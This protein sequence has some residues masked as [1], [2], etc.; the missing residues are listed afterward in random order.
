MS[1]KV[2]LDSGILQYVPKG[3]YYEGADQQFATVKDIWDRLLSYDRVLFALLSLLNGSHFSKGMISHLLL[4]NPNNGKGLVTKDGPDNPLVPVGLDDDFEKN[5][6]LFNLDKIS[7]DSMPRALKNLLILTG[8]DSNAKRVNN[9]RTRKIILEFIFNRDNRQLDALAVNY[10]G[11]LAK[12]VRHALGKQDLYNILNHNEKL[13]NKLIGRYNRN[14]YPIVYFLFGHEPALKDVSPYFPQVE[15]YLNCRT[16]AQSG[17]IDEF[18]KHMKKLPWRT[19]G[20]FNSSYG[21]KIEKSEILGKAKM[22]DRDLLQTQAAQ[23]R[24]GAKTVRQVNYKRQDLYDLWKLYY[25]K[26]LNND[27]AEMDKIVEALDHIDSE[28]DVK[29]QKMDFGEVAA[30]VDMSHSMRGSDERPLHPMLT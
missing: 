28:M 2:V 24:A 17:E 23:K 16:A 30:V 27:G 20:G 4:S 21:L 8:S 1:D 22:S 29:M 18:K 7:Q 6:I 15:A 11:K 14:C 19:V 25:H 9:S 3:A 13:F 10:K 12:L 5:I 26:I